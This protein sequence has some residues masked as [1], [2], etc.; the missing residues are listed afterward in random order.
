[1]AQCCDGLV[2]TWTM[3]KYICLICADGNELA[4]SRGALLEAKPNLV[5]VLGAKDGG[6]GGQGCCKETPIEP[7]DHGLCG[8]LGVKSSPPFGYR[9]G[10]PSGQCTSARIKYRSTLASGGIS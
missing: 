10:A 8:K 4:V 7:D 3:K 1:M 2:A 9:V 6:L 5:D